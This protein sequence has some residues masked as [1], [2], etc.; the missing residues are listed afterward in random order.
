MKSFMPQQIVAA[1]ALVN[2]AC[3]IRLR[4][5][6]KAGEIDKKR[7]KAKGGEQYH[8]NPTTGSTAEPVRTLVDLGVTKRQVH[9]W[10]KL[11]DVPAEQFEEALADQTAKPTTAA[12]HDAATTASAAIRRSM[13][14]AHS[15]C[16]R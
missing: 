16:S 15:A 8:A 2:R 13:R 5:E 1:D 9:D 7:E 4:A 11:A 14:R 3:E 12:K 6:R 10:R